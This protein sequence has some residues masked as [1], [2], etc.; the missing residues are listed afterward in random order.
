MPLLTLPVP[1]ELPPSRNVTGPVIPV[2]EVLRLL[3]VAVKVTFWLRYCG[4]GED[5]VTVVPVSALEID[6]GYAVLLVLAAE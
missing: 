5:E 2:P 6:C 3:T 1:I 4:F